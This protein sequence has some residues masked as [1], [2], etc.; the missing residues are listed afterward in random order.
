MKTKY[1]VIVVGAGPAGIFTC[2]EL[3]LKMPEA[4]VLLIDKGHDI[5]SRNCPI[6]QKKIQKCP[7]PAG[8]KD[9]AGCVPACSITNGFGGAGAYSDG[10]FN[11]TSEFG[12][13]MTDYLSTDTVLDLIHYV[14]QINLQHGAT[15]TITDPLTEK[16]K[17]IEKRAYSAGLK[18]LR[19]QVRHLGTEQNLKILASIY[20]YLNGKIDMMYKTEVLDLITERIE[21]RHH[22]V[23]VELKDGTQIFSK[24]IVI[25]PGRD[26][27]AWLAKLLRKRRVKM[28]ANQ[29]DIGV[30]VET[31]NIVMEEINQHLYEGKFIFN[32]SVGTRVRTFC[33]NPSGHVVVENHSGIMLANGHAYKD[34]KLGSE[35]TNFALLVSHKFD[36]PFDQPTEYAHEVSRLANQ[37]SN[38]SVIVQ[39]Y[40]DILKGRRS[41]P[42]RIK[43]GFITPTL[44]EAVPG[45]LGLVLPYNTM[46]SLIEM[47]EAL[48]KVT[49][50][51]AS[52][53]TLFYGVEAKFYSARPKLNEHFESEIS[54]LYLGGDGA[55]ITRGL[56]QASACGV[57]IARSI[58]TKMKKGE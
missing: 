47:V 54:G 16:V 4:K 12:G 15:D 31:S 11:I 57:W 30:R 1:D 46:K 36:D 24:Q 23:G 26:G 9:F 21:G 27:S 38:G 17:E 51:I 29:V 43:E 6:L 28:S 53:H 50:G 48:D 58:I 10:K 14:D 45:D 40:G 41:T 19:A 49:P 3:S 37:L 32:T 5:Y 33:S 2:Y 55:G 42:K 13:W 20:E 52:E 44:K 34:P 8:K 25:V 35:N 22:A 56:A 39:K 18:L 7:P